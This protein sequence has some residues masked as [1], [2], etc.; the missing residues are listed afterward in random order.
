MTPNPNKAKSYFTGSSGSKVL[1]YCVNCKAVSQST[2]FLCNKP[3]RF[4]T[5]ATCTSIGQI[6]CEGFILSQIPKSTPLSSFRTIQRKNIFSLL[7][8]D[9]FSGVAICFFVLAGT[10][11]REKK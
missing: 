1:K 11:S 2:C 6:S 3:K 9:F 5:L 10:Y 4:A 8:F 7:Q